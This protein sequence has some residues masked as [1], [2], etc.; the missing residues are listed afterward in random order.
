MSASPIAQELEPISQDFGLKPFAETLQPL[1][2]EA[3]EAH[4]KTHSR[5]L[6]FGHLG[7][8]TSRF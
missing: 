1:I 8:I 2:T 3:L 7:R 6:D 4:D 5:K